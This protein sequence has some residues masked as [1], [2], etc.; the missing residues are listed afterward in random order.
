MLRDLTDRVL[1][2]GYYIAQTGATVRKTKTRRWKKTRG[3]RA[4]E[5]S[6]G[7]SKKIVFRK[8]QTGGDTKRSIE[9]T[10]F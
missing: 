10:I 3:R 8:S 1:E 4:K 6:W 2:E 5:D 7:T 9:N